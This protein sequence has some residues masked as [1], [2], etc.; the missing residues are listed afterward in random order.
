MIYCTVAQVEEYTGTTIAGDDVATVE[1]WIESISRLFDKITDRKLVADDESDAEP[2]ARY[3][4]GNGGT[5]LRIDD[6]VSI[7]T[8]KIGDEYG[9][10]LA[11]VTSY[12]TYPRVAPF[13]GLALT[14]GCFTPGLQNVEVTGFWGFMEEVSADLS[15]ACTVIVGGVL[16][17]K[18]PNAQAVKSEK[19]GE[20]QVTYLD[21]KGIADYQ[22]AMAILEG[23]KRHSL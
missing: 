4:D 22:R 18:T 1:G 17:T 11:T 21:D 23:Y 12:V 6:C 13:R 19:I 16:N 5:Q 3:F 14:S 7:A 2:E 20:Y 9:A 15:F 10:N 8:L